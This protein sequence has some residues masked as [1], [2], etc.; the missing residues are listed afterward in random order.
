MFE[1]SKYVGLDVHKET[2]AVAVAD[3]VG[4]EP[5]FH[6]EISNRPEVVRKLVKKFSPHGEVI[7][8]CYEAGPCG[9]GVYR[10]ITSLGHECAVVA[11]SLIKELLNDDVELV[12]NAADKALKKIQ[13]E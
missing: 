13:G 12:K 1:Y 7:A 5:T 3:G 8:F 6:G 9:Y 10:Q 4:G 11:P 2:I